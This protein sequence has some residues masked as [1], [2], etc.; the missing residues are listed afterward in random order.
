M[1]STAQARGSALSMLP[2]QASARG[3]TQNRSQSFTSGEKTVPHRLVERSGFRTRFGQIAIQRA[4]DL[5]LASLVD[6]FEIHGMEAD[7][8][9]SILRYCIM[10]SRGAV[11]SASN[12]L[13]RFSGGDRFH[14]HGQERA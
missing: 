12:V 4:V 7:A 6:I 1:H 8:G 10:Q 9:C 2:R 14:A 13:R 11:S 3:E 5:F